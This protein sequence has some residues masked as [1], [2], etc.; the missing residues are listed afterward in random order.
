MDEG[1]DDYFLLM[2]QI[3]IWIQEFPSDV[4][5]EDLRAFDP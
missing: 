5:I 1:T 4:M 3:T 2:F